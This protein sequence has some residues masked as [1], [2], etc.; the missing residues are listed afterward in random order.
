MPLPLRQSLTALIEAYDQ[1]L[2]PVEREARARR[3]ADAPMTDREIA[4]FADTRYP[5]E[6]RAFLSAH[7]Q[8]ALMRE[9]LARALVVSAPVAARSAVSGPA[10]VVDR[11]RSERRAARTAKGLRLAVLALAV[12]A[13]G[14]IL[15][16]GLPKIQAES[17]SPKPVP[18]TVEPAVAVTPPVRP[19]EDSPCRQALRTNAAAWCEGALTGTRAAS[20]AAATCGD[21]LGTNSDTVRRALNGLLDDQGEGGRYDPAEARARCAAAAESVVPR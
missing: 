19:P 8:Q 13:G 20:A 9:D 16:V 21:R 2:G 3:A 15:H 11:E 18:T 6:V 4:A 7:G 14:L 1:G 5:A 12:A 10:P 17:A